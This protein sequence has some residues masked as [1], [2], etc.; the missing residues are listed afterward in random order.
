MNQSDRLVAL[1]DQAL[2]IS[3]SDTLSVG[4]RGLRRHF[5]NC[6]FTNPDYQRGYV[7]TLRQKE[8]FM[9]SLLLDWKRIPP[10]WFNVIGGRFCP[11]RWEII[12][13]KQRLAAIFDWLDGKIDAVS[14]EGDRF[15]FEELKDSEALCIQSVRIKINEVRLDRASVLRFYLQLNSGGAVHTKQELDRV[16]KLLEETLSGRS[17]Q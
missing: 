12:D 5:E 2:G 4:L 10:F 14:I 17:S 13:G 9:G 3:P 11:D 7:W 8:L 16:R 6:P 15:T 1:R